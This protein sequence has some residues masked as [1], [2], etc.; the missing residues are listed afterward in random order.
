MVGIF[1]PRDA[2][3]RLIGSALA[4]QHDG[5]V[6][7]RRYMALVQADPVSPPLGLLPA[8]RQ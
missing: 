8:G 4:E 6:V 2:I 3:V 5:S 7:F 1:P